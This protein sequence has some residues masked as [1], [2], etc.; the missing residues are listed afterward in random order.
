[1]KENLDDEM[2]IQKALEELPMSYEMPRELK[3][4]V[5]DAALES[6]RR[7][8]TA[9]RP[10]MVAGLTAGVAA[11][12]FGAYIMAPKPAMAKTWTLVRQAVERITSFQM[13]VKMIDSPKQEV[14][15]IASANGKMRIDAGEGQ[16]VYMDGQSIQVYDPKENSVLRLKFGDLNI[17]DQLSQISGEIATHFDL[18]K[19]FA[20]FEKKYGKEN[21]Q[22]LPIRNENG[23][24]VYDVR[25]NDPKEGAK[26]FMTVDAQTDL[27]THI[28]TQG[29][30]DEDGDVDISLRYN[31]RIDIQ[32]N[33]PKGVKIEE[34]DLTN[35]KE[36]GMDMGKMGKEFGAEM[37]KRGKEF[38]DAMEKWGKEMEK[39]FGN[40]K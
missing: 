34:L 15:N 22:I 36:M 35:L 13:A 7:P 8:H 27:P 11:L 18:K 5:M 9:R 19:E 30:K 12:A 1:M 21:I 39:Q 17:G 14:V 32:P 16:I 29:A 3:S 33:L 40:K 20:D 24:P 37:E 6:N 26:V 25:M 31:D 2:L 23:R 28:R 10:W 4:K 38:G